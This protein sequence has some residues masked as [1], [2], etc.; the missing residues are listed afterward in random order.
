MKK[1]YMEPSFDMEWY[2]YSTN[3]AQDDSTDVDDGGVGGGG[4]DTGE[5]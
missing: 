5:F 2:R 4:N 3:I 1:D